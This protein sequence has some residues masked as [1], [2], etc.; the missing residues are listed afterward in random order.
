MEKK[1]KKFD[2]IKFKEI[3]FKIIHGISYFCT[4]G[5]VAMILLVAVQSCSNKKTVN[6]QKDNQVQEISKSVKPLK[7]KYQYRDIDL[8]TK[9]KYEINQTYFITNPSYYFYQNPNVSPT[10]TKYSQVY[11]SSGFFVLGY[12]NV[13]KL[14]DFYFQYVVYLDND[15]GQY[16]SYISNA[17]MRE[18]NEDGTTLRDYQ[19][20]TQWNNQNPTWNLQ[21]YGLDFTYLYSDDFSFPTTN[22]YGLNGNKCFNL[23]DDKIK[24]F[25]FLSPFNFNAPYGQQFNPFFASADFSTNT[26]RFKDISVN[27]LSNGKF[28][29]KIRCYY[30]FADGSYFRL[31][32]NSIYEVNSL[33]YGYFTYMEYINTI[34]NNNDLVCSREYQQYQYNG[35]L[36]YLALNNV[37]WKTNYYRN[38]TLLNADS[39]TLSMITEFNNLNIYDDGIGGVS[40]GGVS[41]LFD[42]LSLAFASVLPILN[43]TILP[44][45]S[46]GLLI[47]APLAV[48]II[49]FVVWLVKR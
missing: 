13:A 28:Y 11:K 31:L 33:G 46:I 37:V 6:V 34:T 5:F 3:L 39:D 22:T 24:T 35:G 19:L 14:L 49:I 8:S 42:L 25:E 17:F 40:N 38:I 18:L 15:S 1:K 7:V 2:K 20:F 36:T 10:G 26:T 32:D 41:S 23:L 47:F 43:I 29:N 16:L 48:S 21:Q 12:D 45:L 44:G 4:F 27:F 30:M 9:A